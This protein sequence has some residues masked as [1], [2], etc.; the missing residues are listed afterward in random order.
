[1]IKKQFEKAAFNELRTLWTLSSNVIARIHSTAC[2]SRPI[3]FEHF[4][5][6]VCAV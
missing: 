6:K 5:H 4:E 1:M 3:L 2:W